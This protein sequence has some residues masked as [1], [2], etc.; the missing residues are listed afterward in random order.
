[1]KRSKVGPGEDPGFTPWR[2]DSGREGQTGGQAEGPGGLLVGRDLYVRGARGITQVRV[3]KRG[4]LAADMDPIL[5]PG[6]GPGG[7]RPGGAQG[8]EAQPG[9]GRAHR[10][11]RC[12][13]G[14]PR[15]G[16]GPAGPGHPPGG[17][18][19]RGLRPTSHGPGGGP[20][21]PHPAPLGQ[22]GRDLQRPGGG[23]GGGPPAGGPLPPGGG[24]APGGAG[25]PGGDG[26][27]GGT[28]GAF[29][30]GLGREVVPGPRRGPLPRPAPSGPGPGGAPLPPAVG[31]GPRWLPRGRWAWRACPPTPTPP[32]W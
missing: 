10:R 14:P 25:G 8:A 16:G 24:G 7:V 2:R 9:H 6:P 19:P 30:A 32:G 11:G 4:L 21:D 17:G 13:G 15:G 27:R 29:P 26:L 31:P 18:P 3:G 22:G 23:R 5:W 20:A 12:P 28:R 1:V